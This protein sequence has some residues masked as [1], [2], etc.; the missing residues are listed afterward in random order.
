MSLP[1]D[2]FICLLTS[3]ATV[4]TGS[5]EVNSF[6]TRVSSACKSAGARNRMQARDAVF[7]MRQVYVGASGKINHNVVRHGVQARHS[8]RIR[9]V[10]LPCRT[11]DHRSRDI[12]SIG[13]SP[14]HLRARGARKSFWHPASGP[15]MRRDLCL[16]PISGISQNALILFRWRGDAFSARMTLVSY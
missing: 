8:I 6:E 11:D 3:H 7:F 10:H 13:K 16:A 4:L 1:C 15:D 12:R 14:L 2:D 9:K 5:Y